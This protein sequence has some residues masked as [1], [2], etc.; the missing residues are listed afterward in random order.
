MPM[1]GPA[2]VK[3]IAPAIHAFLFLAMWALFAGSGQSLMGGPSRLPFAILLIADLP[4][5]IIAF[6][7]AFTSEANAGIAFVL[8]GVVG[9]LWW[10][11]LGRVIDAL[12]RRFRGNSA[13]GRPISD[14]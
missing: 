5:S 3:Y 12:I 13:G 10:Y 9:T 7:F 4:F 2:Q 6:G 14:H 11:L 8:W 1:K